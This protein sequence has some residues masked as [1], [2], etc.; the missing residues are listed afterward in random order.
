MHP[1]Q[2]QY[3]LATQPS[4]YARCHALMKRQR[5]AT[6][7][8]GWPTV[9]ALRRGELLGFLSTQRRDDAVVAGP[10]ALAPDA[11]PIIIMRLVEAYETVMVLAGIQFY[12][13]YLERDH[14]RWVQIIEKLADTAGENLVKFH[15][16]EQG[17]WYR[18]SVITDGRLG[19]FA[20]IS[21]SH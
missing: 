1:E 21:V 12:Y 10:V 15:A 13:F 20:S 14:P 7:R 18:R 5:L 17:V 11:S 4:D 19:H 2:T 8:M 9:M 16:D 3:L 6:D